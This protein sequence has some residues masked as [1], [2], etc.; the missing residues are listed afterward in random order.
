MADAPRPAVPAPTG[1]GNPTGGAPPAGVEVVHG[2]NQRTLPEL[3]GRRVSEARDH[4]AEVMN[5]PRL[6]RAMVGGRNVEQDYVLRPGDRLEFIQEQGVKG[7]R[8]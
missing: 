5:I 3:V 7:F 8:S 6:P 2:A 4:L 1:T